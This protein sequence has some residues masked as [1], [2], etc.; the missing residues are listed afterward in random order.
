MVNSIATEPQSP[1]RDQV[2]HP[3]RAAG[4]G[5]AA[6]ILAAT[7][8]LWVYRLEIASWAVADVLKQAG[9][10]PAS[11]TVTQVG[12]D[13]LRAKDIV[14]ANGAI[15][16]AFLRVE[17]TPSGLL[18]HTIDRV[19]IE[20]P[21]AALVSKAGAITLG[22]LG[23]PATDKPS[24]PSIAKQWQVADIRINQASLAFETGSGAIVAAFSTAFAFS[25]PSSRSSSFALDLSVPVGGQMQGMHVEVQDLAL[26]A[27]PDGG[28]KLEVDGLTITPKDV[29]WTATHIGG[30][31]AWQASGL[32]AQINTMDL[33]STSAPQI[34]IPVA[35]RG[36]ATMVGP[37]I[38]FDLHAEASPGDGKPKA[39]VGLQGH[40][41]SSSGTGSATGL[42]LSLVFKANGLQPRDLMPFLGKAGLMLAGTVRIG[43]SA[44]WGAD[45]FAPVLSVHLADIAYEPPGAR[46]SK[47]R[48]DIKLSGG[49]PLSTPSGQILRATVETGGLRPTEAT[50]VFQLLA[51][52]ELL[53]QGLQMDFAGGQLTASPFA[54]DPSHPAVDTVIGLHNIDVAAFFGLLGVEGLHGSGRLDGTLPLQFTGGKVVL[55]TGH[56]ASNGPGVLQLRSEKLSGQFADAGQSVDLVLQALSDF[57][58]DTLSADLVARPD[59]SGTVALKLKGKNPALLD[60]RDF[61]INVNLES[62]L[63]RLVQIALSSMQAAQDLLRKSLGSA[64]H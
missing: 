42:F 45:G 33:I 64:R 23:L 19:I 28:M 22:G 9:F 54:V 46:L 56:V 63:D 29:P 61:D 60:G 2:S 59:G 17:A 39:G 3:I 53:I 24:G 20:Q 38:D 26:L 47:I 10:G 34:M 41:D 18:S 43:G 44:K 11:V 13:G 31:I 16:V 50:I 4:L 37:Q 58:Y 27:K 49:W 21:Q 52:P 6:I 32:T 25:G 7:A 12:L 40:H 15:R 1:R 30:E 8:A 57:H 5:I 55:S 35:V 62:N 48:G 14:A 51:K 36:T